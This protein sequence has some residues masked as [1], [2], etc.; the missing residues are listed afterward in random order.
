MKLKIF[1]IFFLFLLI[2]DVCAI[3]D[4]TTDKNEFS[5]GG[6]A[7]VLIGFEYF[8][9]NSYYK[10]NTILITFLLGISLPI[11]YVYYI[12][13]NIGIG[14]NYTIGFSYFPEVL[15]YKS[16]L[17]NVTFHNFIIDNYLTFVNKFGKYYLKK[18]LLIEYGILSTL[19]LMNNFNNNFDDII[20]ISLGP[21][22]FIGSESRITDK[23]L[24]TIGGFIDTHFYFNPAY[25][26]INYRY[27]LIGIGI[28]FRWRYYNKR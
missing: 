24:F 15:V 1:I 27:F 13:E 26:V 4:S 14:I 6:G 9:D 11:S 20:L 16:T 17:Y 3:N 5:I 18:N 25:N 12:N 23:F 19:K 2:F 10:E 22:L 28:E 7:K 8:D 21:T